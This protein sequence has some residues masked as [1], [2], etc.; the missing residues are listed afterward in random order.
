MAHIG[1]LQALDEMGYEVLGIAGTS[2]GALVAALYALGLSPHDIIDAKRQRHV[3]QDIDVKD[4]ADILGWGW[5]WITVARWLVSPTGR[6][7]IPSFLLAFLM[8]APLL[9]EPQWVAL[10]VPSF[11]LLVGFMIWLGF[12]GL[13]GLDEFVR[14]FDRL[15][16]Q[17]IENCPSDRVCFGD[18]GPGNNGRPV[19][20]IVA[21]NITS[22]T[23]EVFSPDR[24]PY[25]PISEAVAASI[26]IPFI[27]R[28]RKIGSSLYGRKFNLFLDGGLVSN[29]PGW[30]FDDERVIH[31]RAGTILI[32]IK[33]GEVKMKTGNDKL[34]EGTH[35][36]FLGQ[37]IRAALFGASELN[38]RGIERK[39]TVSLTVPDK[40]L[41]LLEFDARLNALGNVVEQARLATR[42]R[43]GVE[44]QLR[45]AL[46]DLGNWFW[47]I[48][49]RPSE[50]NGQAIDIGN[51]RVSMSLLHQWEVDRIKSKTKHN[52]ILRTSH[53][54]DSESSDIP[55][56]PIP[57]Y[58]SVIGAAVAEDEALYDEEGP[59]GEEEGVKW[60][61]CL[62]TYGLSGKES[63]LAPEGWTHVL[64]LVDGGRTIP[65]ARKEVDQRLNRVYNI[66][67]ERMIEL[68]KLYQGE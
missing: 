8:A 60:R 13:A 61:Y 34:R 24:T 68:A 62:P 26:C 5:K 35:L 63:E 53:W 15:A 41:R 43:I 28:P 42:T 29:L 17:K 49:S 54:S 18:F 51:V 19:L 22:G 36:Q 9:I 11:F 7:L 66:L 31:G 55:P 65:L 4:A 16:K 25:T 45:E 67:D 10:L 23:V 30:V 52:L 50:G 2:A 48:L 1:A 38:A 46:D 33:T 40:R 59:F 32:E 27:F 12:R 6:V 3:L 21:T 37:T 57:I 39:M 64:L 58:G 20:K 44:R 14:H 47:N 56:K